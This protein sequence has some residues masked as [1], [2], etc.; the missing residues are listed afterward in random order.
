MGATLANGG[1]NPLTDER[2]VDPESCHYTLAVFASTP[3][4]P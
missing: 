2:V 3:G 4:R 1:V